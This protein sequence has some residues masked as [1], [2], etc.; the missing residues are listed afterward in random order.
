MKH[1]SILAAMAA[2]AAFVASSS[3]AQMGGHGSHMSAPTTTAQSGKSTM[4]DGEVRKVDRIKG[5]VTLKHGP[6]TT[7]GMGPM[8]MLFTATDPKLLANVKEGDK[9]RFEPGQTSDG[10]LTVSKIEVIGK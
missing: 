5:T 1:A 3:M 10:T 4:V 2:F 9:V 8:T 7:L 6:L